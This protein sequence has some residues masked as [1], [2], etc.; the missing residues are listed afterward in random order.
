MPRL[1]LV[2][3]LVPLVLAIVCIAPGAPAGVQSGA[4]LPTAAERLPQAIVL[5]HCGGARIVEWKA[6]GTLMAETQPNADAIAMIDEVCRRAMSEYPAF[7][8]SRNIVPRRSAPDAMPEFSLL[9]GNALR[10]GMRSRNLN[11]LPGRFGGVV[12]KCCYWG[13]YVDGLRHVFMRNDPLVRDAKSGEVHRN[14]RFLRTL[15]HELGHILSAR[16]G[17]WD[18]AHD[19]DRDEALAEEFV[20]FYG[21]RAPVD[22]AEDDLVAHGDKPKSAGE[23]AA[24]KALASPRASGSAAPKNATE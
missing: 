3:T 24:R 4:A 1:H 21:I 7:L 9:P 18:L 11:D 6:T 13:L 17:V 10:D 19:R 15:V 20:D 2:F 23:L 5:P 22:S 8:K 14:P 16:M 12:A